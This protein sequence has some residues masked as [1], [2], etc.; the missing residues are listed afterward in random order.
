M[1]ETVLKT[2]DSAIQMP[3]E[4]LQVTIIQAKHCLKGGLFYRRIQTSTVFRK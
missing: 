3:S 1:D 2:I 4:G